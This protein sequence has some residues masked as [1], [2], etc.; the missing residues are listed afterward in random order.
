MKNDNKFLELQKTFDVYSSNIAILYSEE[1]RNQNFLKQDT[2][3][4]ITNTK[5]CYGQILEK[6]ISS[7]K[8]VEDVYCESEP[9][10]VCGLASRLAVQLI[11]DKLCYM[12]IQLLQ[13][14][15]IPV[16]V[17]DAQKIAVFKYSSS[18]RRFKAVVLK[19]KDNGNK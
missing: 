15:L 6:L 5:E 16:I 19:K 9:H 10:I 1:A 18:V 14:K 3:A 12:D 7:T 11:L 4:I 2:A 13:Y 17:C 8:I